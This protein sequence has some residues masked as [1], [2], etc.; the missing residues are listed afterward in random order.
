[1]SISVFI[2]TI[3]VKKIQKIDDP[4]ILIVKKN[5]H[6]QKK[7]EIFMQK[8]RKI[9]KGTP[10]KAKKNRLRRAKTPKTLQKLYIIM[11]YVVVKMPPEGRRKFFRRIF[12]TFLKTKKKH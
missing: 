2:L 3:N 11:C 10:P 8:L 4:G 5:R 12:L 9:R 6:C 7:S 1:M